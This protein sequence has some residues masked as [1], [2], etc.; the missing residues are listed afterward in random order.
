LIDAY[1]R[2][3]SAGDRRD[4][5]KYSAELES[6]LADIQL[7]GTPEQVEKAQG[8]AVDFAQ[9]HAASLD[10]LLFD[11]RETLRAELQLEP[12]KSRLK[13]LRLD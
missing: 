10:E 1:R 13:H 9:N 6:A 11:L 3:E 2:L 8:F 4:L 12:V 7:F 5:S